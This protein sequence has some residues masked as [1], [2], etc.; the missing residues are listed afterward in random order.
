MI[1]QDFLNSLY[2]FSVQHILANICC[3]YWLYVQQIQ[4]IDKRELHSY[5]FQYICPLPRIV[6]SPQAK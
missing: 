6:L 4:P 1:I 2:I 5:I 3:T